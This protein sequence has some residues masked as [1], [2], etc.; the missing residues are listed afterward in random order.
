[1]VYYL[2][3]KGV[4]YLLTKG[5]HHVSAVTRNIQQ[6]YYF[7]TQILGL[8][9][10][11]KTVNQ[12]DTS[13]YHLFYADYK[14]S[15]GTD[16]TFFEIKGSDKNTPGTNSISKT[17]FRV[18]SEEALEFWKARFDKFEVQRGEI[19]EYYGKLALEFFDDED[20]RL[21][22]IVDPVEE[23]VIPFGNNGEI[24]EASRI[25]SL[26]GVEVTVQY[27][28]PFIQ[29]MEFLGGKNKKNTEIV[30]FGHDKVYI[31]ELRQTFIEQQGYGGV[32]HFALQ[33]EDEA[34][35]EKVLDRVREEKYTNSGIVDRY[36]FKSLYIASPNN[37]TV[38]IATNG[39]GFATDEPLESLGENLALPPFLEEDRVFI[40]LYLKP[41]D[42]FQ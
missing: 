14:G 31:K 3:Y 6:N 35:L 10:V 9:L 18:K 41:V 29:F 38:E 20:Q 39:P 22:L 15:P 5:I 26:H 42:Q 4:I 25:T 13:M 19:I 33:V 8:R 30:D 27:S 11:K 40:E 17:I 12:D 37:I 16:M 28:M 24:E 23:E 7:M 32:H 34:T 1:M 21:M 36:Y 2:V